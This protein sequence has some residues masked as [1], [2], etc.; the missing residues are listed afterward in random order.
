[1]KVSTATEHAVSKRLFIA[2]LF[3]VLVACGSAPS[4]VQFPHTGYCSA[5]YQVDVQTSDPRLAYINVETMDQYN[6]QR[7]AQELLLNGQRWVVMSRMGWARLPV[8]PGEYTIEFQYLGASGPQGRETLDKVVL[9]AGEEASYALEPDAIFGGYKKMT[10][11]SF[12]SL[13]MTGST[14]C[15]GPSKE[16]WQYTQASYQQ[17][18]SACTSNPTST[19]CDTLLATM[20][21]VLIPSSVRVARAQKAEVKVAAYKPTT[22]VELPEDV[23]LDKYVLGLET[24]L[25]QRAF[26]Q[27]V[28][29]FELLESKGALNDPNLA[30]FYGE[31]LVETGNGAKAI[32]YLGRYIK[33]QGAGATHYTQA[34]M[35]FNRAQ[36]LL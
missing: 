1:M 4:A 17:S 3:S 32:E 31:A 36:E 15:L 10:N 26:P 14:P 24:A 16:P 20:P 29:F 34:L 27:A 13:N 21:K 30:F 8:L 6:P 9:A 18:L 35:L 19:E 7:I 11:R 2:T 23:L 25:A 5:N 33:E 22:D 12:K 28:S